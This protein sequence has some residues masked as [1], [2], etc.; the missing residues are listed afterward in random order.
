MRQLAR[1]LLALALLALSSGCATK[2]YLHWHGGDTFGVFE[3]GGRPPARIDCAGTTDQRFAC[4]AERLR[5]RVQDVSGSFAVVKGDESLLHVSTTKPG[6]DFPTTPETLFP[7]LSVTKMFTA[8]AA[9]SLAHAGALDLR[10]PIA[11]YLP[12]LDAGNELGRVTLHH[13]LTHTAGLVDDPHR[14]LCEGNGA[15]PS[16]VARAHIGVRPGVVY[17]YSNLGYALAGLVIE[18][19]TSSPFESVVRDRVLRPL[20]MSTATFDFDAVKVRGYPEGASANARCR[21][22]APAGG[23]NLS[24]RDLARWARSLSEPAKHPLGQPLVE[25]LTTPYVETGAGVNESYGYGVAISKRGNTWLYSHSGGVQNFT[26]FVAWVPAQ[27]VGAAAMMN[28]AHTAGATPAAAVLTTLSVLL[29]L[30]SDFRPTAQGAPRPLTAYVGTYRDQKSWLG[31]VRVRL[32]DDHRLAFDYLDGPPALLP[33]TFT[34][35]FL[36]NS[37]QAQFIVTPVGIA[38]RVA[39]E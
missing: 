38:E 12:E 15:L 16:A 25:A 21:L 37:P 20:G 32:D 17:N 33:A 23:L 31:R 18:R 39:N 9:V 4:L 2:P 1:C 34:F 35:R 29:D 30:P 24:A 8:A 28:A 10:R 36:P 19:T 3:P 5:R 26:A 14:P 27:R 13:L 22:T 7:V 11:S 6:Q